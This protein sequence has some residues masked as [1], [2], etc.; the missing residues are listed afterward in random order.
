MAGAH[1]CEF[2]G[3]ASAESVEEEALEGVVIQGAVGVRD[4]EAVVARMEGCVEVAR[5]VHETMK[6][7]L[8][9]VNYEDCERV[10]KCGDKVVIKDIGGAKL[11]SGEGGDGGRDASGSGDQGCEGWVLAS[12]ES[13][14]EGGVR[15]EVGG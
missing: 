10:L 2:E 11:P 5:G 12:G 6:K 15:G 9:C 4:V 3:E 8:P 7:V 14:C 1:A 13:A